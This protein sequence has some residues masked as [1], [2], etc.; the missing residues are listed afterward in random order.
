[1]NLTR[2]FVLLLLTAL[3]ACSVASHSRTSTADREMADPMNMNQ[4]Q[5]TDSTTTVPR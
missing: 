2:F 3:S 4:A 1:M 5:L